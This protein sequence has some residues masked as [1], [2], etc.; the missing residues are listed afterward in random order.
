MSH[1]LTNLSIANL[2]YLL[3]SN[4]GESRRASKLKHLPFPKQKY[5]GADKSRACLSLSPHSL[6]QACSV[7]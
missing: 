2:S 4:P 1:L 5:S 6:Q 7:R 3:I